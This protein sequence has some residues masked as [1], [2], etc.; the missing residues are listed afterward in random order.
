[1]TVEPV[2]PVESV[3]GPAAGVDTDDRDGVLVATI[4]GELDPDTVDAVGAALF[5]LFDE[6]PHALVVDLA[7]AF[8]S[9][10]G[11]SML[12]KLHS[13]AQ[14][15]EIGFAVVAKNNAAQDPLFI[16]GLSEVL[17]LADTVDEAVESLR[18]S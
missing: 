1:M 18:K 10:A 13:R 5:D 8:M 4:S 11:L 14:T 7:V 6:K 16:S 2:E 12:L 17:P 3:D 15:D 9:S